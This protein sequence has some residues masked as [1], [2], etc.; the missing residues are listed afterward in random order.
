MVI[1]PFSA[2]VHDLGKPIISQMA[3]TA[4]W[5]S[6]NMFHHQNKPGAV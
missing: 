4:F 3:R 5:S 6:F 2:Q 1:Y